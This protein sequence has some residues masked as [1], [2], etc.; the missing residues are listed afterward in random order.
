MKSPVG[1]DMAGERLDRVVSV[2]GGVSRAQAR[3]LV[4][5]GEVTVDGRVCDRPRS[6]V[7]AGE[8][9]EFEPETPGPLLIPEAVDLDVVFEDDQVVVIDKPAGMVVHPGAGHASG[10]LAAGLL[11]LHSEVEGVGEDGRWGIVHRLDRDTSGLMVV[12]LSQA[13]HDG[14]S[15]QVRARS[16]GRT[17]LAL[18]DG[19]FEVPTGTV[20]APIGRDPSRPTKWRV[21]PDGRPA[22][23]H[24]SLT[25]WFPTVGV[26]QLSVHLETGR[27]HQIRVHMAAIDHPLVGDPVYRSGP[28]R[29]EV[30]RICLHS[31]S[32][33][34]DHPL[35]GERLAFHSDLPEDLSEVVDRLHG[36]GVLT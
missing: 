3:R 27:T 21:M 20:D 32:L 28:D 9:I 12:A 22:R 16:M 33:A 13:A 15:A 31:S 30:P 19:Q 8:V 11:H 14:L 29:I 5:S 4:E 25:E 24:Y 2:A 7:A 1:E 18:V 23:T 26:S 10:T 17:Y 6:K 34:F 35:S 36:E